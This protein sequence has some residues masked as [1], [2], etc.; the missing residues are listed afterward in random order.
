[1]GKKRQILNQDALGK[2]LAEDIFNRYGVKIIAKNIVINEY[3]LSRIRKTG[4]VFTIVY[5]DTEVDLGGSLEE[6]KEEYKVNIEEFRDVVSDLAAG[7][8]LRTEKIYRLSDSI[9]ERRD[10]SS[11]S[12]IQCILELKNSDEYTYTHSLNVALYSMLLGK[13]LELKEWQLKDLIIASTL[14]DLGKARIP[15][16]ILNKKGKLSEQEFREMKRHPDLGCEIAKNIPN[17]KSEVLDAISMHHERVDG[18]GYPKGISHDKITIYAKIISVVDVYDALTSERVYKKRITPF[19]TFKEMEKIGLGHFDTKIFVLFLQNIANY[20]VGSKVRM[21]T[22]EIGEI[23]FIPPHC[24]HKPIIRLKD[25]LLD[26]SCNNHKKI[27][28]MV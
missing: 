8:S 25:G 6:Q 15:G 17:I 3:V 21:D 18:S 9:Y 27:V 7:R 13:W 26:L 24:I 16:S 1:M 10:V 5:T 23:V 20:Y 12:I 22:G 11:D 14:H 19:E 2:T 28:E 4:K